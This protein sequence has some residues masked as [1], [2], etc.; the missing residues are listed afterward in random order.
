[1]LE[2][3]NYIQVCDS[4]IPSNTSKREGLSSFY[5][6]AVPCGRVKAGGMEKQGDQSWFCRERQNSPCFVGHRHPAPAEHGEGEA[7]HSLGTSL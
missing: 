1:M 5:S 4:V 7:G 6:T 3:D 2:Y